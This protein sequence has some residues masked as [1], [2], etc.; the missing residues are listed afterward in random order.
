MRTVRGWA[1]LGALLLYGV[2]TAA[3]VYVMRDGRRLPAEDYELHG[4]ELW[5]KSD[6]PEG[7]RTGISLP[8][9]HRLEFAEP[10][11][12]GEAR[13]AGLLGELDRAIERCR[14]TAERFRPF[15]EVPGSWWLPAKLAELRY[16]AQRGDKAAIRQISQEMLGLQL[17]ADAVQRLRIIQARLARQDHQLT[18]AR[19]LIDQVR[20]QNPGPRAA[21]E[22]LLELGHIEFTLKR[23]APAQD[24]FLSL[25]VFHPAEE[26]LLPE[27]LLGSARAFRELNLPTHAERKVLELASR[28]GGSRAAAEA[29]REFNL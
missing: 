10:Q 2:C 11:T 4:D 29:Q 3:D 27:A 13:E 24:A 18:Q 7:A 25:A 9:L 6:D 1:A 8:Q 5:R 21:A 28:F 23:F 16:V 12:L 19:K 26:D 20:S 15:R 17:P 14:A 22:A